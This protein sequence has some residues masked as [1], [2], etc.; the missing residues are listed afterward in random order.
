MI[1]KIYYTV[2]VIFLFYGC[3]GFD[4]SHKL[5]TRSK[6]FSKEEISLIF[7]GESNQ[8]MRV[9]S[10]YNQSDSILLRTK[11]AD[12][13]VDSE[14]KTLMHLVD[15]MYATVT[16][17]LNDGVGI[18]AP[19]IGILKNIIWVQRYDKDGNPFEVYF[20]P[21][22]KKYTKRKLNWLE[23]CLSIPGRRDTTTTRSYAIL[24]EYTDVQNTQQI[25]MVEGFTAIIFQHEIDHINGILYLDRLK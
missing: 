10:I 3:S 8:S 19:Q 6:N 21:K 24:L 22:I 4:S 17:S 14:D 1:R 9:L 16:D 15:R 7:S 12:V 25:E 2:F 13:I 11:C 5:S 20:N 18:A 23:G